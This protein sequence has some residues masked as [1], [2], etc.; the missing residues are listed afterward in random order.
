MQAMID[1]TKFNSFLRK[2]TRKQLGFINTYLKTLSKHE[3]AA[4]QNLSPS[5][6]TKFFR[7]LL[8]YIQF[9]LDRYGCP[10]SK[11]FVTEKWLQLLE[12]GNEI[13]KIQVLKQ[14]SKLHGLTQQKTTVQLKVPKIEVKFGND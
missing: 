8:P 13:T 10:I 6:A 3:A 9:M 11:S 5:Q 7:K 14:L 4:S 12:D 2:C 1:E